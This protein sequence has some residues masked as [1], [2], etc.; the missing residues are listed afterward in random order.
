[1]AEGHFARMAAILNDFGCERP[2]QVA[3]MLDLGRRRDTLSDEVRALY[4]ERFGKG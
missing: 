2:R 3:H 4:E 1:M